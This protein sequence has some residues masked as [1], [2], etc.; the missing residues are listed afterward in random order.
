[1][2]SLTIV[3]FTVFLQACAAVSSV[4]RPASYYAGTSADRQS[5]IVNE[6]TLGDNDD[7]IR[8]L[9]NYPIKL[10]KLSRIAIL[11]LNTDN[12]WRFYSDDFTQLTDSIST[13]LIDTLR[14]SERVY[15]A[16]FLPAMLIPAQKTVPILREATA[17]FQA[18]LLLGYRTSCDSYQKYNFLSADETKSY[19]SVEAVLLDVRSGI[20]VKSIVS[21]ENFEALKNADD[22]N[23]SETVKKAELE[24]TAKALGTIAEQIVSYFNNVPVL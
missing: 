21:V 20:I 6:T 16:S 1:M 2:K 24:A 15:D 5:G 12:H 13:G 18:D 9:L 4:D 22:K 8:A 23:F 17:R 19:C 10:P 3:F 14:A 7:K 11:K